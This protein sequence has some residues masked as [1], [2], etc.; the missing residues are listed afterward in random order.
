MLYNIYRTNTQIDLFVFP[1]RLNNCYD[2]RAARIEDGPQKLF[3]NIMRRAALTCSWECSR[4]LPQESYE[5]PINR[6]DCKQ[7]ISRR[8]F[9]DWLSISPGVRSGYTEIERSEV[10][11]GLSEMYKIHL[12]RFSGIDV[13]RVTIYVSPSPHGEKRKRDDRER[14]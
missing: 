5:M 11:P 13:E 6:R 8:R 10:S 3:I 9:G 12:A 7:W 14:R 2:S 1:F 4:T